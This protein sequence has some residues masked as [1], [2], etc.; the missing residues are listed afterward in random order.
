MRNHGPHDRQAD[1][2]GGL[3][4]SVPGG[5]AAERGTGLVFDFSDLERM[6]VQDL[7]V[8]LTARQMA[9]E[10]DRTVWATG[11]GAHTWKA[12]RAMGLRGY[13]KQFPT[14]DMENA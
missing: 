2:G 8:M 13:F 7:S 10:D 3:D 5:A 11:V 14:S 12:L 6:R 4:T 1:G 9:S